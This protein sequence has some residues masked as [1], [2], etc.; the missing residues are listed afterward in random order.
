MAVSK[1]IHQSLENRSSFEAFFKRNY[2][3]SCLV[4]LRYVRNE[5][6]AEDIV[7]ETF[8]HLWQKRADL[9]I[10]KNLKNYLLH[11][12]KNRSIN[13]LHRGKHF[14]DL[15]DSNLLTNLNE[16]PDEAFSEEELAVQIASSIDALPNQCKKIFLLAYNDHLTYDQIASTLNLSKN[17]IKTQMGIAYKILRE[18][19]RN[20]F[21]NLFALSFR[22]LFK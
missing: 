14:D 7:Q 18:R 13:Y 3:L 19:L 6:E 20:Y 8:L 15:P 11:A 1:Y 5:Q 21:I 10:Q 22:R 4:A 16:D 2:H 9:K 12:V 17:T